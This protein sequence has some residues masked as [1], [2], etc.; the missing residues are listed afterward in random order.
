[1]DPQ[2]MRAHIRTVLHQ[3]LDQ[4][5]ERRKE[6]L[7]EFFGVTMGAEVDPRATEKLAD[8]VPPILPD[9]YE[10]WI[11]MFMDRLFETVPQDHLDMLCDG[12]E[13]NNAALTLIYL[14]FLESERMEKQIDE[15]LRS[16]GLEHTGDH[17]LGDLASS[18][19][20]AKMTQLGKSI[21]G[22]EE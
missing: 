19:I 21:K 3:K 4:S 17:D 15:D 1:M 7:Q 18:Y 9:L 6:A 11:G 13:E 22:L 5:P 12:K 16:Y 2:T 8:C 20:R 10:K 14:M